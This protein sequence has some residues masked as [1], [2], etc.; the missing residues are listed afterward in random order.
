MRCAAR[1]LSTPADWIFEQGTKGDTFYVICSGKAEILQSDSSRD[2]TQKKLAD[3]SVFN[4]FG[5]IALLKSL[6]RSASV[7]ATADSACLCISR[8]N[9]QRSLG[10]MLEDMVSVV[11]LCPP[12]APYL[13]LSSL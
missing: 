4:T 3:L 7:R 2:G 6:P 5:E 12:S 11:E 13:L 1:L 10:C 8:D 9:F